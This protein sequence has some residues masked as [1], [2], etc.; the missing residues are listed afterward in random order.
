MQ[1]DSIF[2]KAG[3]TG[4]ETRVLVRGGPF[5]DMNLLYPQPKCKFGGRDMIV[6]ATYVTC[7]QKP[8]EVY[9]YEGGR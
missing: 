7:T 8:L 9:E 3:P 4:G 6:G 5:Q 1:I 2:P